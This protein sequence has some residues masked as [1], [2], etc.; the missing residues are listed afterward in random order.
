MNTAKD[1][2]TE[3]Q[4]DITQEKIMSFLINYGKY[5][6]TLILMFL[7][8]FSVYIYLHNESINK[9]KL[10]AEEYQ[11]IFVNT[12]VSLN[13]QNLI[14]QYISKT[15]STVFEYLATLHYAKLLAENNQVD[16]STELLLALS[17]KKLFPEMANLSLVLASEISITKQA[18]NYR[19]LIIKAL[20]K[21]IEKNDKGVPHF[22]IMQIMLISLMIEDGQLEN[23][24]NLIKTMDDNVPPNI[25]LLRNTLSNTI[26]TKT[27]A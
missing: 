9:Q 7:L 18:K 20:T 10:Y 3:V 16:K 23:A 15:K 19:N 25:S 17:E 14:E 1:L 8:G 13:K 27:N 11:N 22:Y 2:I 21:K 12:R 26:F 5:I 6:I 4:K 24:K